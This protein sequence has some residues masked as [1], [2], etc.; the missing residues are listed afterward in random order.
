M[1]IGSVHLYVCVLL[2]CACGVHMYM[3]VHACTYM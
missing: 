3:Y 2:M 1:C